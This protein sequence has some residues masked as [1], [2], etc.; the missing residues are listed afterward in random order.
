MQNVN[1]TTNVTTVLS[2]G[3][4][5]A[6]VLLQNQSDTTMRVAVSAENIALLSATLGIVLEAGE[7]MVI[8]GQTASR[9][10]SAIHAGSG[11]KVLHWQVL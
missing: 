6:S 7:G 5:G 3:N 1:I 2:A 4:R 11:N 9:G 8:D 10:V